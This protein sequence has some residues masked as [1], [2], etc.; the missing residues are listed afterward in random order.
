M[1]IS[2]YCRNL[3]TDYFELLRL[4][5]D[6]Y[7]EEALRNIISANN[8]NENTSNNNYKNVKRS[9]KIRLPENPSQVEYLNAV[10]MQIIKELNEAETKTIQNY[11]SNKSRL[12]ESYNSR[13]EVLAVEEIATLKSKLFAK[14]SCFLLKFDYGQLPFQLCIVVIADFYLSPQQI[15][16]IK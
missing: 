3:V 5:L 6:T 4:D 2:E 9:S 13:N 14:T 10:R 1:S 15:V 11:N 16:Y 12:F 8:N 7:R